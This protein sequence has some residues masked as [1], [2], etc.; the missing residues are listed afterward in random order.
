M[1]ALVG[2]FNQEKALVGAFSVIVQ[3]V[4]EPMDR[5]AA[6]MQ[7]PVCYILFPVC[8]LARVYQIRDWMIGSDNIKMQMQMFEA[9]QVSA[10]CPVS[11]S[12]YELQIFSVSRNING[13]LMT[14]F[15]KWRAPKAAGRTAA[16]RRDRA[17][18]TTWRPWGTWTTTRGRSSATARSIC[19]EPP[20]RPRA[21]CRWCPHRGAGQE[22]T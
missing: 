12:S 5:F 1:K 15:K 18:K 3:P 8:S 10:L 22:Q 7:T 4:V 14:E 2:A 16:P 9:F 21:W 13:L 11:I 6:L 17:P 19:W 20:S